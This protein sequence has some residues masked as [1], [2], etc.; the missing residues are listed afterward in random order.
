MIGATLLLLNNA[1]TVYAQRNYPVI[2]PVAELTDREQPS[3]PDV[4]S[5]KNS[6]R[7]WQVDSGSVAYRDSQGRTQYVPQGKYLVDDSGR[8]HYLVDPGINGEVNSASS[9]A[10]SRPS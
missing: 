2:A 3:G 5:D 9:T 6:Y 4:A 8:I 7:V 1:S 10:A